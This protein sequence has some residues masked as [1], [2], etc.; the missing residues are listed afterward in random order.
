MLEE[1]GILGG[2]LVNVG[3]SP[4]SDSTGLRRPSC[5]ES[6]AVSLR[7]HTQYGRFPRG[8]FELPAEAV[9]FVARQ[10]QVPAAELGAHEWS[11]RTVEYH[12]TRIRGHLGFRE[13][14]VANAEKVTGWLAEHVAC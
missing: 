8:R 4:A 12:R 13:C 10:V 14:S 2:F 6:L 1:T 5:Q 3:Y 9:E 7:F 11:G